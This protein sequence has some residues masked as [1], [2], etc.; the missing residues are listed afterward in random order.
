ML[1]MVEYQLG[2]IPVSV[3]SID[4]HA[5]TNL[6]Q[7]FV[8][9][10]PAVD[11]T[12]LPST[13]DALLPLLQA[14]CADVILAGPRAEAYQDQVSSMIHEQG[15]AMEA[16]AY[17]EMSDACNATLLGALIHKGGVALIA[18]EPELL[19]SFRGVAE[20]NGWTAN[21]VAAPAPVIEAAPQPVSEPPR[22]VK[23]A[24][25]KKAASKPAKKP[26]AKKAPVNK[27]AAKPAPKKTKAP[28]KKSPAKKAPAKKSAV[29]K[30]KR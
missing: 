30:K 13:I 19:N 28:A 20:A 4:P 5:M 12:R 21:E 8:A 22:V 10:V 7:R 25:T 3:R 15:L 9:L 16:T 11:L 2:S 26:P 1:P 23:Q 14:G 29:K 6:P 27:A 18:D 24:A 17:G